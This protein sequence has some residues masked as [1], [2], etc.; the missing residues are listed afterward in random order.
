MLKQLIKI[1]LCFF[2]FLMSSTFPIKATY[3]NLIV[4]KSLNGYSLI[5]ECGER[6]I[7]TD[8]GEKLNLFFDTLG[9][10]INIDDAFNTLTNETATEQLNTYIQQRGPIIN[11]PPETTIYNSN[12]QITG[13]KRRVSYD[14]EGEGYVFVAY[15][16]TIV[17]GWSATISLTARIK[18]L[19]KAEVEASFNGTYMSSVDTAVTSGAMYLVPAGKTGAIFFSPYYHKHSIRYVDENQA[20]H[21]I[22]YNSPKV[23]EETGLADGMF[24]LSTW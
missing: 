17:E 8:T 7:L 1:F 11:L 10:F 18:S 14:V 21:T 12:T 4:E 20:I 2:L 3:D 24:S 16:V 15:S 9:N 23:N 13:T 22:Y 19:I 6:Y 5:N